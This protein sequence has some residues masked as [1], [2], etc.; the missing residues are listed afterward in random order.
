MAR[1]KRSFVEKVQ[2]EMPEFVGEVQGLSVDD[3][4]GR[5]AVIAKA[6][7][8]NDENQENDEEL[9]AAKLNAKEL[10]DAYREPRK[11]LRTKTKYL[12]LLIKEKGGK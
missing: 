12:V 4:N 1:E 3:L 2:I 10:G 7:Q 5:L 9:A 6:Q 11:A 8:E